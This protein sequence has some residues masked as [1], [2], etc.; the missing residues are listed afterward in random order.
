MKIPK[1]PLMFTSSPKTTSIAQ[2]NTTFDE[3][4]TNHTPDAIN[5]VDA[6]L[7]ENSCRSR[8]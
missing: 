1:N 4:I 3:N 5:A 6:R 7:D 2:M 8:V